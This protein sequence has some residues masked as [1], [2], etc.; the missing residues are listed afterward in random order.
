MPDT[1]DEPMT[2]VVRPTML[3]TDCGLARDGYRLYEA[4]P[5]ALLSMNGVPTCE[6]RTS[7]AR[8]AKGE[9]PRVSRRLQSPNP[10]EAGADGLKPA[11][12]MRLQPNRP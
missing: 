12:R 4:L 3:P 9:P 1:L 2:P 8:D 7:A 10:R 6:E 5:S 11:G